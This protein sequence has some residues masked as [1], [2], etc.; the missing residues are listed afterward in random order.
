ML[1]EIKLIFKAKSEINSDLNK[2]VFMNV[3]DYTNSIEKTIFNFS[4]I[5]L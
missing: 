5:V 1:M 3:T 4:C 2:F